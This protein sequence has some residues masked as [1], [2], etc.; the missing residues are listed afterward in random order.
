[1]VTRGRLSLAFLQLLRCSCSAVIE[2]HWVFT[3]TTPQPFLFYQI[4]DSWRW[5]ALGS[6][7]AYLMQDA[8]VEVSLRRRQSLATA[9]TDAYVGTL[10]WDS[11]GLPAS[12]NMR[13]AISLQR[14]SSS[15][16]SETVDCWAKRGAEVCYSSTT[17]NRRSQS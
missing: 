1:V 10:V 14:T 13:I 16:I 11:L 7:M 15:N 9:H 3:F 6:H 5:Q 2:L 8:G 17:V 12:S 4:W